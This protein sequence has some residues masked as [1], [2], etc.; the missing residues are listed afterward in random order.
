LKNKGKEIGQKRR[1]GAKE[2]NDNKSFGKLRSKRL[3]TTV[4]VASFLLILTIGLFVWNSSNRTP[5]DSG[6]QP[7]LEAP[8]AAILDGLYSESPNLG[9]SQI[10]TNYLSAAGYTVDNFRGENVT[11]DLIRN[12]AGYKVMVLRLHSAIH[13]DRNLYIFSGEPYTESK[14]TMEQL[15]GIVRKANTTE[16]KLYFAINIAFL[17]SSKPD[18]LKGS[19]VILMG[20]HGVSDQYSVDKLLESG[21]KTYFGWTGYVDLSHT[22]EATLALVKAL[23]LERLS[24]EQAVQKAM[25]E[26]GPDPVYE[27]VYECRVQ[28]G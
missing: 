12:V 13:S 22:D 23:C 26:V 3:R 18:S 16:G 14:Y 9:F 4:I 28:Q 17:G 8:K 20:C 6:Q 2:T 10:L 5:P 7:G 21:V 19:T 15:A 27:T 1:A 11:I 24:P 25:A